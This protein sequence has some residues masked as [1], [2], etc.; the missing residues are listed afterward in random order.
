[1]EKTN[2]EQKKGRRGR[3]VIG[4]IRHSL[5]EARMK[6]EA[7]LLDIMTFFISFIFSRCHVVFGSHPLAIAFIAVLPSR[8]WIAV[9]GAVSG[10]LTLGRSGIIYSM[11]SVIVVFLR[12]IVSGS[13]K[14]EDGERIYLRWFS[15]GLILK[16]SAALIGGFIA[17]VYEV[18]ISGFTLA[19][20]LFGAAM[21][22]IP[23]LLVFALSGLFECG[24]SLY[25]VFDSSANVFGGKKKSEK[26]KF[27]LLFF[28]L[29]ALLMMFLISISFR[30]Y[31][32]VG[33][34]IA[35]I[36]SAAATLLIARR[37]GALYGCIA[38]FVTSF[39]LSSSLSVAFAL[40]GIGAGGLFPLGLWYG[41]V[42]GGALLGAWAAYAEALV[43][44]LGI[45][46]EYAIAALTVLPILKKLSQE[47]T[48][49]ECDEIEKS[50]HDMVGTVALSYRNRYKGNLG[51]LELSLSAMASAIKQY[52]EN[53][54]RPSRDELEEFILECSDKYCRACD[55]YGACVYRSEG[56]YASGASKLADILYENGRVSEEDVGV[57]PEYC[58]MSAN[59]AEAIN[60]GA[61]MLAEQS[62]RD[63]R[64]DTTS[65][66]FNIIAKLINEARLE[67]EREKALNEALTERLGDVMLDAGLSDGVIRAFGERRP[68]FI[69][70]AEDESGTRIT[71]PELKKN[72]EDISGVRLGTP[73]FYR[74][75]KMAL[76]E[77]ASERSFAAE[78][79]IA[80]AA[81]EREDT[82]G[83]TAVHFESR[84]GYF[85]ALI[86]DGM[87]SGREAK[88][89]S[90]LVADFM[91]RALEFSPEGQTVLKILNHT[92]RHRRRE[93]SATVDLFCVDLF[94]GAGEFLKSGA[95]A[96]YVK[97]GSSIF[98]IKSKTAPLGLLKSVDAEKIKIELEGEEYVVMLSDGIGQSAEDMPWLLEL[99]AKPP[100]RNLAEYADSILAAAQ[101]NLPHTDDMTVLVVKVTRVRS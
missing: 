54:T 39:G 9:L 88:Q 35:Y 78:C 41:V 26:D 75:G 10:A 17:A 25:T 51:A 47:K 67:D 12:I 97:R 64:R 13:E 23:P 6:R 82:S 18:L 14:S 100:K 77:C 55:G 96:S 22:L 60:R 45:V 73:E 84:G 5:E 56:K 63:M 38:G 91:T 53:A 50:A 27:N 74:K 31:D 52:N 58:Q 2:R 70:A 76:M 99:L 85:Y 87:G 72:I 43:G 59:V 8:V 71:A 101:K 24:I 32:L 66:D 16:M 48:V 79:A 49:A 21:I 61:A 1:M 11:I 81:G 33:I 94:R 46:P 20:V 36:F 92:V 68:Y 42:G 29:S 93:C 86:S 98:R 89:T 7:P 37:F 62:F 57:Y 28:R 4:T 15:E 40:A 69:L 34:S 83:D 90:S 80:S 95:A 3:D 44:V 30:E 65:D 19:A